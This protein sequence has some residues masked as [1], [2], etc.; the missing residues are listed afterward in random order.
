MDVIR[1]TYTTSMRLVEGQP[2]IPIRWLK[3][4]PDAKPLPFNHRMGSR[5]WE[6]DWRTKV[7]TGE[8]GEIYGTYPKWVQRQVAPACANPRGP[9]WPEEYRPGVP[10]TEADT[11]PALRMDAERWPI[12][13][14]GDP[15]F[16]PTWPACN[17]SPLTRLPEVFWLKYSPS[18]EPS[19]WLSTTIIEMTR[20]EDGAWRG[21]ADPGFH[22]I[23]MDVVLN[24]FA[25][26]SD[27]C[28]IVHDLHIEGLPSGQLLYF[29][30]AFL[31]PAAIPFTDV[32]QNPPYMAWK[33]VFPNLGGQAALLC[34]FS[35]LGFGSNYLVEL[36]T[37]P[38]P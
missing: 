24:P 38:P 9:Y 14:C 16:V 28:K 25:L 26:T 29:A 10:G 15:E 37:S 12:A 13:C 20:G 19:C 6:D 31:V 17:V 7:D 18:T 23:P 4:A 34:D 3:C 36:L 11:F 33:H 22:L 21:S 32:R 27:Q 2:G 1:N 5:I 8:F 35:G 30:V